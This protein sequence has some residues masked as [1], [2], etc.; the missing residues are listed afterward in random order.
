LAFYGTRGGRE[1]RVSEKSH[2]RSENP[3]EG[4]KNLQ[5]YTMGTIEH[6]PPFG[7]IGFDKN[8]KNGQG[9]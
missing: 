1:I 4:A 9:V 5:G 7:F 2:L 3:P 8:L 6:I